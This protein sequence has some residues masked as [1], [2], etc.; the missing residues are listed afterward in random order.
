MVARLE[1]DYTQAALGAADRVMLDYAAKLTRTPS[2]VT[3]DDIRALRA[4]GFDDRAIL[5]M[6]QITAYYAY[7]NRIVD[8][9]GVTLEGYWEQGKEDYE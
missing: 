3:E 1:A 8:G 7:A 6:A 9:L 2:A 5:D 4:A